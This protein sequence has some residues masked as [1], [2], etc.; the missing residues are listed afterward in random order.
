MGAMGNSTIEQALKDTLVVLNQPCVSFMVIAS[1]LC[2]YFSKRT[3]SS[4][5]NQEESDD[6]KQLFQ[7]KVKHFLMEFTSSGGSVMCYLVPGALFGKIGMYEVWISHFLFVVLNDSLWGAKSLGN[8]IWG[9]AALVLN[10]VQK[11]KEK[12]STSHLTPFSHFTAA[13]CPPSHT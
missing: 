8:P 11:R 5:F 6:R 12:T 1:V 4:R 7:S 10:E 3:V 2:I 13:T 9:A